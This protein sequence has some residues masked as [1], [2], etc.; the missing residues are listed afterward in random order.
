MVISHRGKGTGEKENSIAAFEKALKMG[1]GGIECDARVAFNNQV[2]ITHD[3]VSKNEKNLL[4]LREFLTFAKKTKASFFIELK[5]SSPILAE[6][7]TEEIQKENLWDKVHLIGFSIMI[8]SAL[9]LQNKYPKLRVIPFVNVPILSFIKI[10]SRSY[11]LFLGWIEQWRGSRFL[12]QNLIRPGILKKL[13][14]RYEE[15]GF[16]VI[17]GVI[18]DKKG[19]QYFK[20]AGITDIVTDELKLASR[21][22]K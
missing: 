13:R 4:T 12:F 16:K 1:A 7:I 2:V 22:L 18:N 20:N 5:N 11:G 3:K 19:L 17:A 10:P 9:K 21:I 15:N 6:K 14:R 8:K